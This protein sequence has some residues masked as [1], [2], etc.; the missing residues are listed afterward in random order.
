MVEEKRDAGVAASGTDEP[1]TSCPVEVTCPQC[2]FVAPM[3]AL[4]CPR[5]NT[6]LVSGCAGGCASCGTRSCLR[7]GEGS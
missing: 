2:G 1:R 4:R 5:C 3:L 6:L 7:G